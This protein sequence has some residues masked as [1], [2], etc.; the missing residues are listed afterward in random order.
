MSTLCS[1]PASAVE[2]P[3]TMCTPVAN[4]KKRR[5]NPLSTA[6]GHLSCQGVFFPWSCRHFLPLLASRSPEAGNLEGYFVPLDYRWPDGPCGPRHFKELE[7]DSFRG[8]KKYLSAVLPVCS[9]RR[10][11]S[12]RTGPV[13]AVSGGLEGRRLICLLLFRWEICGK[14]TR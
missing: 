9:L 14:R 12:Q 11:A 7:S 2:A 5:Q 4:K 13:L 10:C 6:S 1:K 3:Q 8:R